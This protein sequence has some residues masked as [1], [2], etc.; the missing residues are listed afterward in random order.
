MSVAIILTNYNMPE[1]TDALCNAINR[2]VR[3]DYQLIVVDNGSDIVKPSLFTR[4]YLPKNVQTTGGWLEGLK[5]A[6]TLG[7]FDY[8]IFL[9]TSAEFDDDYYDPITPMVEFMDTHPEAVGIHP[10]LTK[11]STTSW[12]HLITRGGREPRR[13]WMIDNI[14]SMYRADWFNS[15]GRFD[16]EMVYAWGIDLET[17]FKART[18]GRSLWVDERVRVKKITNIGY[19]MDRMNMTASMRSMVAGENMRHTLFKK[20]GPLYWEMMTEANIEDEW[21]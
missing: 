19:T 11:D 20:Y 14:C 16:P 9:I 1:R 17:C 3:S 21:R 13:T 18:Q 8:Y 10:A 2:R 6:D 7:E 4:V 5:F 12:T 15:I